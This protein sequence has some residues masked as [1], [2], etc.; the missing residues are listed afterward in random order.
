MRRAYCA[1]LW[2]TAGLIFL[3]GGCGESD[4][5]SK[6]EG[7]DSGPRA[8]APSG[9]QDPAPAPQPPA[10]PPQAPTTRASGPVLLLGQ[11]QFVDV[12]TADG[13]T[14][15]QPGPARLVI[16]QRRGQEWEPQVLEDPESNVFHKVIAYSD[17]TMPGAPPGLMTA[18]AVAA[19]IKVWHWTDSGWAART[20]WKTTFGGKWDRLRDSEIGDVTGDGVDDIAIVTHD[21]GVVAVLTRAGDQ[22][23]AQEIDRKP[24]TFVHEVELG[25]LDGDG[26]L[27]VYTTPSAPNKF[28][29]TP[30][31]GSIVVYK[32][33]GGRFERQVVKEFP[34]QHPKEILM[35]DLDGDGR[36]TLLAAVE[37]DLGKDAGRDP[38]ADKVVITEYTWDGGTYV[39]QARCKLADGLCRFL[40]AGDVDGDGK[41]EVIASTHKQG[42]W[43]VRPVGDAWTTELIDADSGGFEHATA[44]ADLDGDGVQE[45]YVVADQQKQIRSYRWAGEKWDRKVLHDIEGQKITFFI[46]AG[47]L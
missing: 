34:R 44:L 17:P 32:Y 47:E 28:D 20:L 31:P 22:W 39:G 35:T 11:A 29:G 7:P 37:A 45:I 6:P 40:N 10:A 1:N 42:L 14:R 24:D 36:P 26:L 27:E 8:P 15:P 21:Q 18:G 16:L 12:Q 43:L 19:A 38:S 9:A 23:Q 46:S 25:D 2:L 30:Q 5:V 41:P 13:K 4:S 3:V 33:T